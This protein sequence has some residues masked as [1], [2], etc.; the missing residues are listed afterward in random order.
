M[1]YS[2]EK[3]IKI[4]SFI[5]LL[6]LAVFGGVL[7]VC[8]L[9]DLPGIIWQSTFFVLAVIT[10]EF[11]TKYFLPIYTYSYDSNSF[12]ITKTMGKKTV[13][14]CN[15][16]TDRIVALYT[17]EEYKKQERYLPKSIYRNPCPH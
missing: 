2:P 4:N 17:K 15:I 12:I 10:C 9:F 11:M 5:V 3:N 7:A 14:V 13:T 1:T 8:K 6:I 16:D